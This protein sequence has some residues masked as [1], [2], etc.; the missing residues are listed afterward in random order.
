M[1]LL[2]NSDNSYNWRFKNDKNMNW[3]K[4]WKV[5]I[6][7]K[8]K[9]KISKISEFSI[10]TYTQIENSEISEILFTSNFDTGCNSRFKNAREIGWD[11]N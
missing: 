6:Q 4:R 7:L 2:S 11:K 10:L 3:A 8:R 9:V 1:Y 5:S